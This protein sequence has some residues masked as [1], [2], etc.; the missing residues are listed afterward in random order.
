MAKRKTPTIAQAQR[1]V[2]AIGRKY[3]QARKEY[4]KILKWNTFQE[5][6]YAALAES[7]S[8]E[9]YLMML[10]GVRFKKSGFYHA[11]TYSVIRSRRPIPV[12]E[13][14]PCSNIVPNLWHV[15]C[16]EEAANAF[17][18]EYSSI[19]AYNRNALREAYQ[20][21]CNWTQTLLLAIAYLRDAE[22]EAEKAK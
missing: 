14:V 15:K 2:R 5:M 20:E 3:T 22:C 7:K 17:C 1:E 21:A 11:P 16:N 19:A 18:N 10:R 8:G 4:L 13:L 9:I 12:S 6:L